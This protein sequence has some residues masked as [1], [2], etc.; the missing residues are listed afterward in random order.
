MNL[1]PKWGSL[2]DP[3]SLV[4]PKF[5]IQRVLRRSWSRIQSLGTYFDL[6]FK[7]SRRDRGH[8]LKSYKI[9]RNSQE[10]MF[11]VTPTLIAIKFVKLCF[12]ISMHY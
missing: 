12:A 3:K 4:S 9:N 6:Y 10:P 11:K 8:I 2:G 5:E 7:G 1:R